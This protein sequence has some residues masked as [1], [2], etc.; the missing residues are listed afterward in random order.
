MR[1][2]AGMARLYGV[3]VGTCRGWRDKTRFCKP[4]GRR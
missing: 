2:I 1:A 4:D 3:R